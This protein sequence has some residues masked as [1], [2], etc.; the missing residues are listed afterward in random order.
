MSLLRVVC[1]SD[2][3]WMGKKREWCSFWDPIVKDMTGATRLTENTV[4]QGGD[5]DDEVWIFVYHMLNYCN[6][7]FRLASSC[8][9]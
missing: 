1:L 5:H 9:D 2:V 8:H 3:S 4:A 7:L 6:F